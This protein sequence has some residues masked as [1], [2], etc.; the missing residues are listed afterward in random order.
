M[1]P[2]P[3]PFQPAP[4]SSVSRSHPRAGL[5]HIS[6]AIANRNLI[7]A[8]VRIMSRESLLSMGKRPATGSCTIVGGH[9]VRAHCRLGAPRTAPF[10]F[11]LEVDPRGCRDAPRRPM[12]SAPAYSGSSASRDAGSWTPLWSRVSSRVDRCRA[13]RGPACPA[14][15]PHTWRRRTHW[16]PPRAQAPPGPPPDVGPRRRCRTEA[17]RRR[18]RVEGPDHRRRRE[19]PAETPHIDEGA[20]EFTTEYRIEPHASNPR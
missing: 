6:H 15:R 12:S 4:P 3:T 5:T 7:L 17:R 14:K 19:T 20:V 9:D 11:S 18:H 1:R 8:L 2:P 16:Q 10:P 13:A